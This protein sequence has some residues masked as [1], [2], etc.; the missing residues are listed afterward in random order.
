[1]DN[2][3]KA[4]SLAS[5]DF[6]YSTA[7]LSTG[8]TYDSF[9]SSYPNPLQSSVENSQNALEISVEQADV[10]YYSHSST[11][12]DWS[13]AENVK[14]F[15]VYIFLTT[16]T[17]FSCL[18]IILVTCKRSNDEYERR[19]LLTLNEEFCRTTPVIVANNNVNNNINNANLQPISQL[20]TYH[21]PLHSNFA[22]QTPL[23]NIITLNNNNND[24]NDLNINLLITSNHSI[25]PEFQQHSS[26]NEGLENNSPARNFALSPTFLLAPFRVLFRIGAR[27]FISMIFRGSSN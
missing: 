13:D 26:T 12:S 14:Y 23:P 3:S 22:F 16:F 27:G 8:S 10:A 6:Y 4:I 18:F 15:F 24:I 7:L 25:I 5:S 2:L 21:P 9:F 1:M 11:T 17:F 20:T 19:R